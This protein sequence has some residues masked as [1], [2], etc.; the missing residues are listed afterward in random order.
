MDSQQNHDQNQGHHDQP[1]HHEPKSTLTGLEGFFDTYLREKAPF[2]F[3]PKAREWIVKYGP[4]IMLVFLIL[5]AIIIIPAALLAFGLSAA[6]APYAVATGTAGVTGL[7]MVGLAVSLIALVIEAIAIPALMKRKM[8]GW[9]L[10]YYS[11]LLSALSS[12][13]SMSIISAVIGL[14]VSMYILF[15]IRSYYK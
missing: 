1:K 3:P 6:T 10:V 7:S 2:Q 8:S 15:Q 12:V 14:V 4:W 11:S 9:K 13:L 5:G